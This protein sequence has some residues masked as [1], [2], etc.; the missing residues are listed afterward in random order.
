MIRV[1]RVGAAL[2]ML[3]VFLLAVA[4]PAAAR[5]A[6]Q[7]G[8]PAAGPGPAHDPAVRSDTAVVVLLHGLGRTAASMRPLERA[9]EEAG[10]DVVNLGYPSR[11][12]PIGALADTV[13]AALD[14]CC[15][16]RRVHF[17]THSLGG[18]L[19]R[20]YADRHGGA[21]IGRVVMLSPPN[22]GSEIVDRLR[23]LA[24]LEWLLGPAFLQLGTDTAAVPGELGP[25]GFEVGVITGDESLNPLFSWWIPG[26]DDGKVSVASARLEGAVDFRV[27]PYGHA[28]IMRREEVLEQ[29]LA[30]LRTG[31]FLPEP[32]PAG[33]PRGPGDLRR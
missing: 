27:V 6:R 19:V 29:V 23:G 11:E 31:R 10:Y 21:R 22:A 16:G 9:L 12:A 8:V 13:A 25:P 5:P 3:T 32:A 17:V 26:P 14:A 4:T 28:F 30:F 18:I 2:P 1:P 33:A 7:D 24:P 15:A 20:V